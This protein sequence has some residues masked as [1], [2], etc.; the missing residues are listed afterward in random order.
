M[1]S[2]RFLKFYPSDW[3]GDPALSIC[4]LAARGLWIEMICIMHEADP[5]GTL[6]F[7][8]KPIGSELLARMASL[9][10]G[11]VEQALAELREAGVFDVQKN[12]VIFSRKMKRARKMREKG[13]EN[14]RKRWDRT[15][16]QLSENKGKKPNPNG[17]PNTPAR[18]R[19]R[20]RYQKPDEFSD[21]GASSNPS[22]FSDTDVSS[23]R[24][25]AG[26]LSNGVGSAFDAFWRRYPHKVGKGAAEQAFAKAVKATPVATIMAGLER[27]AAKTDDR[28]WCNPTT[29]LNQRR[30]DDQPATP[31]AHGP[32]PG[33]WSVGDVAMRRLREM[34]DDDDDDS[35]F[36]DSFHQGD[37]QADAEKPRHV[38][39]VAHK[40]DRGD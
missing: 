36:E 40:A 33:R 27:Y 24:E 13:E 22:L 37:A 18:A 8:G 21:A 4:S 35:D 14:A 20:P 26:A 2:T 15:H 7:R 32:P 19:S 1:S 10:V 3:R 30:W 31:R 38:A 12:G 11:E 23:N 39:A 34:G 6:S 17:I 28:P 16:K 5:Y 25:H 9:P 29:F